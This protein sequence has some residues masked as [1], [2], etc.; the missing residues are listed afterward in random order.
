MKEIYSWV[1]WFR[2]L[3]R[4]IAQHDTEFLVDRARQIP[5][6]EDGS[7]PAL[8]GYGDDQ[9]DPFSFIYSLASLARHLPGRTRVY[10]GVE[11]VFDLPG[12]LHLE[13]D[14]EFIFPQPQPYAA[15]FSSSGKGDPALLWRLFR[16][17]V[18][19]VD[20]VDAE[21]FN[22]ALLINGVAITKLTQALFLINADDFLS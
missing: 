3:S 21:D 2:E 10:K 6:K 19:G 13:A 11:E 14:E 4:R 8:F 9:V 5:W 1:P 7:K 22:K 16:A 17:A 15:L 20:S 18:A 12:S